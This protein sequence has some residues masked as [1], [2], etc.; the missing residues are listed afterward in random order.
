MYIYSVATWNPVHAPCCQ[1]TWRNKGHEKY[2]TRVAGVFFS[3]ENAEEHAAKHG[4][5][6]FE[7][8]V[9]EGHQP[10]KDFCNRIKKEH[11]ALNPP[12]ALTKKCIGCGVHF[13]TLNFQQKRCSAKCKTPHPQPEGE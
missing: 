4:K 3:K 13:E 11:K 9:G 6:Y 5:N 7:R 2:R 12:K 1:S 10:V 8:W